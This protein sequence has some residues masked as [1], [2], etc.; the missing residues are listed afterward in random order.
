MR[1]LR[2]LRALVLPALLA[3]APTTSVA[4]IAQAAPAGPQSGKVDASY[5][6]LLGGITIGR[7]AL[8]TVFDGKGYTITVR[9]TTSGVTRFVSD[10]KGFLK[11]SGSIVGSRVLPAAYLLDTSESGQ[12]NSS[13]SMQMN[14]GNIVQVAALPPLAKKADRVPLLPQHKRNIFDPLS[15]MIVPLPKGNMTAACNRTVPVFDGWQRFDVK[16]Y[17]K[18]TAEVDGLNGS[19]KGSVVVCGARYVPVA[20]HRPTREAIEYME[21]NKALEVWLA[22]VEALGVMM[23]YR[24][25]IGT[26][27]GMLTIHASRF[28][29]EAETQRASAE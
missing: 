27:V 4:P 18:G 6:I 17:Y 23:P 22:P 1:P 16:L 2:I 8:D 9:G 19:Y 15:A 11:S 20:G 29:G 28:V 26:E 12:R 3:A 13:V 21:N 25:Q 10:G 7:F 5:T 14:A 24:M